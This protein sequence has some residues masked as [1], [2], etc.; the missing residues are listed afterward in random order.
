MPVVA[1][2]EEV[3]GDKNGGMVWDGVLD[4]LEAADGVKGSLE[5]VAEAVMIVPRMY[6]EHCSTQYSG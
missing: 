4:V 3:R 6:K 5:D 1:M 2:F